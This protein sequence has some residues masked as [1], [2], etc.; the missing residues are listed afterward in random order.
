MH[1]SG[2]FGDPTLGSGVSIGRLTRHAKGCSRQGTQIGPELETNCLQ[3][4]PFRTLRKMAQPVL[5]GDILRKAPT[6]RS[7][8]SLRTSR[9]YTH[10]LQVHPA[11]AVRNKKPHREQDNLFSSG[12]ASILC[13]G[14]QAKNYKAA[15]Q[16]AMKK[17]AAATA[18]FFCLGRRVC[19]KRLIS[20]ISTLMSGSSSKSKVFY[21]VVA[22]RQ[23]FSPVL[24]L[25][26]NG[27]Q[28]T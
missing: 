15:Q 4:D 20:S 18:R 24:G 22:L 1:L 12:L 11:D 6:G 19:A 28:P 10:A 27:G 16:P 5:G 8:P 3:V 14:F 25:L 17:A 13:R 23:L 9:T 2:C 26:P 21:L 7:L